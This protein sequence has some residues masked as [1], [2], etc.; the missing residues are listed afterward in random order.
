[1]QINMNFVHQA[2][3]QTRRTIVLFTALNSTVSTYPQLSTLLHR[4]LHFI[5]LQ[6]ILQ[7]HTGKFT[8]QSI[9]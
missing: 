8:K 6:I 2:G 1:M 5:G 4:A 7:L 3:D 9:I